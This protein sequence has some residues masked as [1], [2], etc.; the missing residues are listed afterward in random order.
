LIYFAQM[1]RHPR[2]NISIHSLPV[3]D[4]ADPIDQF[5]YTTANW[6]INQFL[7]IGEHPALVLDSNFFQPHITFLNT[8]SYGRSV[9]AFPH[10]RTSLRSFR[11]L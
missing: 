4:T 5:A 2:Q 1:S 3:Y 6:R 10:R 8:A 11:D 7:T 9:D